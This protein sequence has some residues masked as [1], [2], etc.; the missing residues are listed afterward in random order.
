MK[1]V[2]TAHSI[3]MILLTFNSLGLVVGVGV[4][5]DRGSNAGRPFVCPPLTDGENTRKLSSTK[6]S[7]P[8]S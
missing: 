8:P 1:D 7:T 2:E 6:L 3:K 4:W 5:M